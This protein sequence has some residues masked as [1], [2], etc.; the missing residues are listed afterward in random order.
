[1]FF[2]LYICLF[3]KRSVLVMCDLKCFQLK[4]VTWAFIVSILKHV[5]GC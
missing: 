5:A 4:K 1:M 3:F 2:L